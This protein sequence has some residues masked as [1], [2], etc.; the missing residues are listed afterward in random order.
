[1]LNFA[2][3]DKKKQKQNKEIKRKKSGLPKAYMK[4]NKTFITKQKSSKSLEHKL[5]LTRE[6]NH[7]EF[8]NHS[9]RRH[10]CLPSNNEFVP[11]IQNYKSINQ[12]FK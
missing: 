9:L 12:V 7:G 6:L 4:K 8:L 2:E 1:M 3:S 11:N 10:I 5:N